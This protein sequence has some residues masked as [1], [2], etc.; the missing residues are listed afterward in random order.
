MDESILYDKLK[1]PSIYGSSVKSVKILQTHI[2]YVVLTGDYA[3][4]IK[5]DYA[6]RFI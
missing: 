6:L 1:N 4:K 2:S 3:Y 5:K